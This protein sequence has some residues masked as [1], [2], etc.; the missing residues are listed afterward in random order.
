M[1][2]ICRT[3][4]SGGGSAEGESGQPSARL[5]GNFERDIPSGNE[6]RI[7][8]AHSSS[9]F[10]S[11]GETSLPQRRQRERHEQREEVSKS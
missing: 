11:E 3:R 6:R 1:R 4:R 2:A 7:A 5:F 8:A 9:A 10:L